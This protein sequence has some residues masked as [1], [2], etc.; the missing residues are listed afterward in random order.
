MPSAGMT[1]SVGCDGALIFVVTHELL[2]S[3]RPADRLM[4]NLGLA[5]LAYCHWIP[6][7]ISHHRNVCTTP[8]LSLLP[9]LLP[10]Y[11]PHLAEKTLHLQCWPACPSQLIRCINMQVSTEKDPASAR[12]GETL[13]AFVP[14]SIVGNIQDGVASELERLRSRRL[15][16]FSLHNRRG[17]QSQYTES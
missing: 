10:S 15:P 4:A 1:A 2:H 13:Y 5:P 12:L 16:V 7:H 8:C 6:S 11:C 14:R 9:T 17:S 3:R